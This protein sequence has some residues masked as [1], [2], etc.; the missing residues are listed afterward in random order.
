MSDF[1]SPIESPQVQY[2]PSDNPKEP[3]V[4]EKWKKNP[5]VATKRNHDQVLIA[6][7]ELEKII[8]GEKRRHHDQVFDSDI[9]VQIT[10]GCIP[11]IP[12]DYGHAVFRLRESR[13]A[14]VRYDY[15]PAIQMNKVANL[16]R[17]IVDPRDPK[18]FLNPNGLTGEALK[19]MM[20]PIIRANEDDF[21]ELDDE[22]K[23]FISQATKHTKDNGYLFLCNDLEC[24]VMNYG[25][26]SDMETEILIFIVSGLVPC[27]RRKGMLQSKEEN[28]GSAIGGLILEPNKYR[29]YQ[30]FAKRRINRVLKA[31]I[32]KVIND[33][34]SII[35]VILSLEKMTKK[36]LEAVI[37]FR[38]FTMQY[39]TTESGNFARTNEALNEHFANRIFESSLKFGHKIM[40][41]MY[42]ENVRKVG[43]SLRPHMRVFDVKPLVT[44][45]KAID[46][47]GIKFFFPN[48]SDD[49]IR[50]MCETSRDR[51]KSII[52]YH[53]EDCDK[54]GMSFRHKVSDLIKHYNGLGYIQNDRQFCLIC[55][56]WFCEIRD[57]E[58]HWFDSHNAVWRNGHPVDVETGEKI[59]METR[60]HWYTPNDLI[61]GDDDQKYKIVERREY[62][63]DNI[64]ILKDMANST[65]V[66]E[67]EIV[68]RIVDPV[69]DRE[70]YLPLVDDDGNLEDDA[71]RL[72]SD[73][74]DE[75]NPRIYLADDVV[76]RNDL[77]R[78]ARETNYV[79]TTQEDHD[80]TES[81]PGLESQHET[82]SQESE[83]ELEIATDEIMDSSEIDS[84]LRGGLIQTDLVEENANQN[85]PEE[86]ILDLNDVEI[87]NE[88]KGQDQQID[89]NLNLDGLADPI[90]LD[91][92]FGELVREEAQNPNFN[93]RSEFAE[94]IHEAAGTT[95]RI[96]RLLSEFPDYE[97]R[98]G[99]IAQ[100]ASANMELQMIKNGIKMRTEAS[101]LKYKCVSI[102]KKIYSIE[103]KKKMTDWIL[104]HS[105]DLLRISQGFQDENGFEDELT[106]YIIGQIELAHLQVFK[107]RLSFSESIESVK[108]IQDGNPF[109]NVRY[110]SEN[111]FVSKSI[112]DHDSNNLVKVMV[113]FNDE[114]RKLLA[115]DCIKR[116]DG[117]LVD[118][119]TCVV[120]AD[121]LKVEKETKR[122]DE[123]TNV[124]GHDRLI[125]EDCIRRKSPT[126]IVNDLAKSFKDKELR[127][128]ATHETFETIGG[129]VGMIKKNLDRGKS[130]LHREIGGVEKKEEK[131]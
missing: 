58:K 97:P 1:I 41:K 99:D 81:M 10:S 48:A 74:F 9:V 123:E 96:L 73:E 60:H 43:E 84:L 108:L 87:E 25:L 114:N 49:E 103:D 47:A 82:S 86:E 40:A 85:Y 50:Q 18:E 72:S 7:D 65:N 12:E 93:M 119:A 37:N 30:G 44:I 80:D 125:K 6:D 53:R 67:V 79:N 28:S 20:Q 91:Q 88:F 77:A 62:I 32:D 34:N 61:E 71:E 29:E 130:I 11:I 94:R 15:G 118:I 31:L 46:E 52:H 39:T 54:C 55:S 51:R 64:E 129:T 109:I 17:K 24:T 124:I 122:N 101:G 92:D 115:I 59:T 5:E 120:D 70:K 4:E 13:T 105:I 23:A 78:M 57:R 95:E 121:N 22:V 117:A 76:T 131:R 126:T 110:A 33:E 116:A 38:H 2:R 66:E 14:K 107:E 104:I 56:R 127:L 111:N 63:H 19:S 16:F 35:N 69:D 106:E 42:H 89:R 68:E 26:A 45:R 3:Y 21:T 8:A 90:D 27:F 128:E 100:A 113:A 83:A 98:I 102:G 75:N 112:M 36:N